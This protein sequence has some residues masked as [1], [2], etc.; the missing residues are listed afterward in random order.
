MK[1]MLLITQK[2]SIPL[3]IEKLLERA[4]MRSVFQVQNGVLLCV[5]CHRSFDALM[6]YI[7]VVD[8][9]L[10]A[11]IVNRTNDLNDEDYHHNLDDLIGIRAVRKRYQQ[12][13][14]IPDLGSEMLVNHTVLTFHK[15]ACLIWKLAGAGAIKEDDWSG[16]SEDE[17]KK[18][19][20]MVASRLEILEKMPGSASP[21]SEKGMQN[22]DS[23][24]CCTLSVEESK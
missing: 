10:I 21:G 23:S 18:R 16:D 4:G 24:S 1:L 19:L 13:A 14:A 17:V 9:R 20:A 2:S 12:H 22:E 7:D 15:A 8:S 5:N 11:K 3:I 6:Q